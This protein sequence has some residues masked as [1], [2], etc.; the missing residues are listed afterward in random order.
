MRHSGA[1]GRGPCRV[2]RRRARAGSA[3]GLALALA[4]L[5]PAC[6]PVPYASPPAQI[7]IGGGGALGVED[8]GLF[9]LQLDLAPMGFFGD[10]D[11]AWD[12]K[13]GY[14]L[15]TYGGDRGERHG[16]TVGGDVYVVTPDREGDGHRLGFTGQAAWRTDALGADAGLTWMWVKRTSGAFSEVNSPGETDEDDDDQGYGRRSDDRD[17]DGGGVGIIGVAAGEVGI[18]LRVT[19][20]VRQLDTDQ[21]EWVVVGGLDVR[22]PVSL[23]VLLIWLQP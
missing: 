4:A 3:V 18:G 14:L 23:G 21:T 12:V 19:G 15:E 16:A 7:H 13:A 22:L 8:T 9:R 2:L 6:I 1:V 20:G 17:D 10:L 5:L 11:R